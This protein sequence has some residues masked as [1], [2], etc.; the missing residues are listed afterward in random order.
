MTEEDFWLVQLGRV[1]YGFMFRARK[2]EE[3]MIGTTAAYLFQRFHL[4]S[5]ERPDF[6][7]NELW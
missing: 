5:E 7:R 6:S 1:E 4:R 3:C 2:V